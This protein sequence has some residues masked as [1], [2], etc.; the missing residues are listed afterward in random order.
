MGTQVQ[1]KEQLTPDVGSLRP[2]G[3]YR[4]YTEGPGMGA[5]G[6]GI[7]AFIIVFII[8]I[9]LIVWAKPAWAATPLEGNGLIIGYQYN[10]L[11]I[12]LVAFVGAL[13]VGAIFYSL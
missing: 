2:D 9:L 7:V 5:G 4:T 3:Y 10:Y 8:I 6:K 12:G 1:V 11:A 13:I